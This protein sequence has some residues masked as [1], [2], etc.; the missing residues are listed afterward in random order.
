MPHLKH[1][2]RDEMNEVYPPIVAAEDL[3]DKGGLDNDEGDVVYQHGLDIVEGIGGKL[4]TDG[5]RRRV[6]VG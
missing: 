2:N 4:V 5:R 6:A 1:P 3:D